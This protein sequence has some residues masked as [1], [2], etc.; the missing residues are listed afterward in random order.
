MKIQFFKC[1]K[2]E[3][4]KYYLKIEDSHHEIKLLEEQNLWKTQRN[5]E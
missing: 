2:C 1:E 4:T 3:A 5:E